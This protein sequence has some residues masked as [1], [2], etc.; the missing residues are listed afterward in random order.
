MEA[1]DGHDAVSAPHTPSPSDGD[2]EVTKVQMVPKRQKSNRNRSISRAW[3][4]SLL[5]IEN[6]PDYVKD[7]ENVLGGYRREM[8]LRQALLTIFMWHNET[9]NI[10][11]HLIAGICFVSL[12]VMFVTRTQDSFPKWPLVVF[13]LGASYTFFVSSL[14]HTVLCVSRHHYEFY[15]KIDFTAIIIVMFSMFWPFCYYVF[16]C[17]WDGHLWPIIYISVAAAVSLMCL[18]VCLMPMFQS[19]AFHIVRPFIF[20]VLSIW[21]V[22]P[23]VHAAILFWDIYAVKAAILLVCLQLLLHC[24]GAILYATQWPERILKRY[25]GNCHV[26]DYV[27]SHFIFHILIFLGLVSFHKANLILYTWRLSGEPL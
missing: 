11:S 8:S 1:M 20:G 10:W 24:I 23:V 3:M 18:V 21:G 14:F 7:N 19:K 13:Q 25:H 12:F 26:S 4:A 17:V 15:R 6:A 5:P 27:T 2:G 9:L 22:V 16:D